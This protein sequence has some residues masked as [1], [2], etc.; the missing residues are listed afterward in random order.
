MIK[1]IIKTPSAEP[2]EKWMNIADI[3][4]V[5]VTSEDPG[6]PIE[7]AIDQ[8]SATGWRAGAPGPQLIRLVFGKRRGVQRIRLRFQQTAARTHEFSLSWA[9]AAG[10]PLQTIV[11]Q[12][13]TFSP[14]GST[15]ECEEY[16]VDLDGVSILELAITPDIGDTE[17]IASVEELLVASRD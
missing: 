14:T 11:R 15:S 4:A 12:Q 6:H 17:A 8:R 2:S 7:H 13:W 10:E 1:H 5:E 3:A 16:N 9:T